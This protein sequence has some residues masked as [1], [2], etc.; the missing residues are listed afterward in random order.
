MYQKLSE[1]FIEEFAE[2]LNWTYV[3][4]FQKLS[5]SFIVKHLHRCDPYFI[6]MFQKISDELKN[7]LLPIE[8]RRIAVA[9][10]RA[11]LENRFLD[12]S[13]PATIKMPGEKHKGFFASLFGERLASFF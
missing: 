13:V 1:S 2:E 3:F 11:I 5:E 4:Q 7:K 9:N 8:F 10:P 6:V 12:V